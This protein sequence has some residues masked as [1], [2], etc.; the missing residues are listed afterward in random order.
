MQARSLIALAIMT[1]ATGC[2]ASPPL[3]TAHRV[4]SQP[5]AGSVHFA[6]LSVAPWEEYVQDLQPTFELSADAA[7]EKVLPSTRGQQDWMLRIFELMAGTRSTRDLERSRAREAKTGAD[8]DTTSPQELQAPA[9]YLGAGSVTA[10]KPDTAPGFGEEY[11]AKEGYEVSD[12]MTEYWAATALYQEVKLLNRY[13]K[14]AAILRDYRPYLVRMQVGLMPLARG[15]PYDAYSTIS[16]FGVPLS[17]AEPSEQSPGREQLDTGDDE[18]DRSLTDMTPQPFARAGPRNTPVVIPLMA[19][20]SLEASS[21][22]R[23]RQ[24]VEQFAAALDYFAKGLTGAVDAQDSTSHVQQVLGHDLNSLLSVV[25]VSDNTLRVRLGAMQQG[26]SNFAMVPRNHN[27][28]VILMLPKGSAST[29][30][31]VAKT[32]MVDAETGAE[33]PERQEEDFQ[34][35]LRAILDFHEL[36]ELTPQD[37]EEPLRYAQMNDQQAF[38]R[39]FE[40][41][42]ATASK[43]DGQRKLPRHAYS[44]AMWLDLVSLMIGSQYTA[45]EFDVPSESAR[46]AE[47]VPG[48]IPEQTAL[49]FDLPE[50][51]TTVVLEANGAPPVP[52]EEIRAALVV[53][54]SSGDVR[55]APV[56]LEYDFGRGELRCRFPSLAR[57]GL[58][59]G[60]KALAPILLVLEWGTRRAEFASLYVAGSPP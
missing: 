43:G 15:E 28:T 46:T 45:T 60:G 34:R 5:E 58:A 10:P 11:L 39:V 16:F 44:K 53:K 13:V 59:A 30:Q 17:A 32:T 27:V 42:V 40:K 37:L 35:R 38:D 47:L 54:Q 18:V 48:C 19:T 24:T 6:V 29:V 52:L 36:T 33:L 21:Q 22:S 14:D 7:L 57:L 9:K 4:A 51:G 56:P 2:H 1:A 50:A 31:V 41:L 3:F 23:A 55:L 20:D 26:S 8:V 12:P 49:A 25:R